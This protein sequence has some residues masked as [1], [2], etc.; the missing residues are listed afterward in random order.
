M[1]IAD[2][3]RMLSVDSS[4]FLYRIVIMLVIEAV[5]VVALVQWRST[6]NQ[7][8]YRALWAFTVASLLQ[9]VPLFHCLSPISAL[10]PIVGAADVLGLALITWGTME[11]LPDCH[12]GQLPL[13]AILAATLICTAIFL[14]GWNDML[15]IAPGLVYETFWQQSFWYSVGFAIT[16][17][18]TALLLR[19]PYQI[20]RWLSGIAFAL[21]SASYGMRL[22]NTAL[23]PRATGSG[24]VGPVAVV[25]L[26][27]ALPRLS[28]LISVAGYSLFAFVFYRTALDDYAE[29]RRELQQASE[30]A[31]RRTQ[32]LL[33]LVETSQAIGKSLDL[34]TILHRVV[35]NVALALDADRCAI[36]LA[37]THED[38]AL[39]LVAHYTPLRHSNQTLSQRTLSVGQQLSLVTALDKK[40]QLSLI[41]ESDSAVLEPLYELLGSPQIGPTIIQPLWHQQR[42]LGLLIV[43]NDHCQRP[44]TA[45]AKRLIQSVAVQV[46]SA[47]DNAWLY[48]DL[49]AQTRE[50][51]ELLQSQKASNRQQTAILESI[52]EGVIVSDQDDRIVITNAAAEQILGTSRQRVQGLLLERLTSQVPLASGMDWKALIRS[53]A[54]L[55]TVFSLENKIV[56]V[57]SA[58]VLTSNGERIGTVA[59]LRDITKETAAERAKSDFITIAS[60][61]L[62]T[63][64]TSIRGYTEALSS[65]MAGKV[66]ET[67]HHFLRIVR[68]NALRMAN[69]TENLIAVSEIE[70]EFLKLDYEYTDLHLLIGDVVVSFQSQLED[71]Q[72]EM[73]LDID[74]G[75]PLVE[76]DPVR[77]RQI[78]DNLVSNALKFTYPG[79]KITIGARGLQ[80]D[81]SHQPTQCAVWVSDTGIGIAPEEQARIWERFYRTSS[82]LAAGATGLGMGLS[83]VKSLTQAHGGRVWLESKPGAGSTFTVLFPTRRSQ[84][85]DSVVSSAR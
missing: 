67:Q 52:A 73:E 59:V 81:S 69:L 22:G 76:A 45:S 2:L 41:Q 77:L 29:S 51:A 57:N 54:S 61:E 32:E 10:C 42:E 11:A 56:Y 16:A 83:I 23:P 65:G 82:P 14:P 85:V 3:V 39:K 25:V 20:E 74:P 8:Y 18:T 31:L 27:L 7:E 40:Q 15:K 47:I 64:L 53:E 55:Q 46:T 13:V 58:P 80:D 84:H 33:F 12:I 49:A 38:K 60:H 72:L 1:S 26:Q 63:P 71:R 66:N 37:D 4:A 6:H 68:D 36:V 75:L 9:I 24:L 19:K 78:L 17:L 21:L 34:D 35:E 28:Q 50:L 48:R 79:G 70:K 5:A 30:D 62:R 43:G 44:F